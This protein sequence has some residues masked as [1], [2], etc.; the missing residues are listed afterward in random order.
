MP[1]NSTER[2]R[3][4]REKNRDRAIAQT[5]RATQ[6]HR[7]NNPEKAR[8]RNA[9]NLAIRRGHIKKKPC[10]ICRSLKVQGHHQDYS[11]PLDVTWLCRKHHLEIHAT[12]EKG[13]TNAA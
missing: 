7:K 8:A 10:L 4:W 2:V 9:L 5:L 12:N 3:R 1:D 6:N 13:H 11:K